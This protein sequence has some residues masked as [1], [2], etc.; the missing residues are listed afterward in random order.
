MLVSLRRAAIP[1]T[2]LSLQGNQLRRDLNEIVGQGKNWEIPAFWGPLLRY[3]SAPVLSIVFSF[4][5]P[6]F[7]QTRFEPLHIFGFAVGHIALLLISLGFIVPRWFEVLIPPTRRGE[8]HLP[9]APGVTLDG[10][11]QVQIGR[12]EIEGGKSGETSS[13]EK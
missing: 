4:A 11:E 3:V 5:Y 13:T 12:R 1:L 10:D 7:Y 6:N 2:V 8:G 9:Y